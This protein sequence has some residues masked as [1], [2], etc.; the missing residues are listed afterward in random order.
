[1]DVLF[2]RHLRATTNAGTPPVE[3]RRGFDLGARG[4]AAAGMVMGI[5]EAEGRESPN[6]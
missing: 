3:P 4:S 1:V 5:G 2:R 6:E